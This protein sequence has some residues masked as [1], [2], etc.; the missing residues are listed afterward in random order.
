MPVGGG[1]VGYVFRGLTN[2]NVVDLVRYGEDLY[3]TNNGLWN[4]NFTAKL[5]GTANVDRITVSGQPSPEIIV[6]SL[7]YPLFQ[8][9]VDGTNVFYNNDKFIYRTGMY[10]GAVKRL[11]SLPASTGSPVVDMVADGLNLY[12]TDGKLVYRMPVGGATP[13]VI[14]WGW[15][16]VQ[17]LA[18]DADNL[19]FADTSGG[20][21]VQ[22]P[23]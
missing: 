15:Q 17:S 20:Y 10:G 11:V 12:F 8:I 19:Y 14:S 16:A 13:E 7:D 4:T 18:V 5:P 23:K 9:A 22:M 2:T 3:Y 6:P 21:V 1:T